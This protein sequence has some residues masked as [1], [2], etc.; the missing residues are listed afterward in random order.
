VKYSIISIWENKL[1]PIKMSVFLRSIASPNSRE[2]IGV[3]R[4]LANKSKLKLGN[5]IAFLGGGHWM[6][7]ELLFENKKLIPSLQELLTVG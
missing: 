5:N 4:I 1:T 2:K 6:V 7:P 3:L